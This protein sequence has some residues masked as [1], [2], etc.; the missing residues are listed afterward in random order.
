MQLK[1][2]LIFSDYFFY[3]HDTLTAILHGERKEKPG[4]DEDE[5]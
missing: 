4:E 5:E 2:M 3:T 1:K